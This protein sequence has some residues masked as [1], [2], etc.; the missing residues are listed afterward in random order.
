MIDFNPS[1]EILTI[2]KF[3]KDFKI[4][5]SGYSVSYS[6]VNKSL[7][8]STKNSNASRSLVKEVSVENINCYGPWIKILIVQLFQKVPLLII[9]LDIETLFSPYL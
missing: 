7:I 1:I 6:F 4:D 8:S 9:Y 5:L 2:R 3:Q